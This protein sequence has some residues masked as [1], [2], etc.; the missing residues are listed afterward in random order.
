MVY[1]H[2]RA[3]TN[4]KNTQAINEELK[5]GDTVEARVK[6]NLQHLLRMCQEEIDYTISDYTIGEI[7]NDV[8][9]A[10]AD[11]QAI[12][13]LIARLHTDLLAVRGG[14]AYKLPYGSTHQ[15]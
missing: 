4:M 2:I 7:F 5:V 14:I 13:P 9:I 6:A 12:S 3:G 10:L 1:H 11:S 15:I 8:V